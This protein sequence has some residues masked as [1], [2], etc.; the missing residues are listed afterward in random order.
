[1][2]E[3]CY[4]PF[5]NDDRNDN[6]FFNSLLSFKYI[7]WSG[8]I[9]ELFRVN[10]NARWRFNGINFFYASLHPILLPSLEGL[11]SVRFF[12]FLLTRTLYFQPP[13]YISVFLLAPLNLNSSL[14]RF[15]NW[16]IIFYS[17]L[18]SIFTKWRHS[19]NQYRVISKKAET[20]YEKLSHYF[21]KMSDIV[22]RYIKAIEQILIGHS[23]Y[24]GW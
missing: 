6:S 8:D 22:V 5:C 23:A 2:R 18:F 16:L 24:P 1:M 3:G 17:Y 4:I 7:W 21:H 20:A 10:I 12:G 15:Y 11:S 14:P 13:M 9:F 19:E